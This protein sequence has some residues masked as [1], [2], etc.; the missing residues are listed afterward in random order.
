MGSI[1]N[2]DTIT[3]VQAGV[4]TLM[5]RLTNQESGEQSY[6][7]GAGQA[8]LQDNGILMLPTGSN[9]YALLTVPGQLRTYVI[10]RV[11]A[12]NEIAGE[13]SLYKYCQ[14]N[15]NSYFDPKVS[16]T[17]FRQIY[18]NKNTIYKDV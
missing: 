10:N 13:A 5:N 8:N 11:L 18:S 3:A 6:N 2:K 14:Y 17:A 16:S 7:R 15:I 9:Q 1:A 4:V 12:G